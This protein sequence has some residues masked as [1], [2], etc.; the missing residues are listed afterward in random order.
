MTE[1]IDN[2]KLLPRPPIVVV[3]G[4][5][6]H[7]KTTLLDTIR[8]TNV[9]AKE[10]GGI[11]QSVGAYEITHPQ[12]NADKK[13]AQISADKNPRESAASEGSPSTSSGRPSETSGRKITFI[14]TPGHEAFSKMRSRGA[15][16]ADLAVL[17][18]AAD[19]GVKP[20]TKES[21]EVLQRTETPFIVAITKIDKSGADVEK[22]KNDLTSAG[23]LLEGYG[24]EVSYEPVSAK[25][26]EHIP[27]LLD[28]ILLAADV[29]HLIY[30]PAAT[31]EGFILEARVDRQRG[32]EA[33]VIVKNGT[34]RQGDQIATPTARGRIKI[35]EN[36]LGKPAKALEPSAPAL[37][38]GFEKLPQV[39][40][41]FRS[42]PTLDAN[43]F[44][45]PAAVPAK[46]AMAP[47]ATRDEEEKPKLNVILK[48]A[49]G[50]ALEALSGIVRNIA[51]EKPLKVA[52]ESVGDV[53]DNDVKL[54]ISTG[55][56][57][58]AFRSRTDK[59]SKSLAEANRITVIASDV[60]YDLVKAIEEFLIQF[61]KPPVTGELEVLAIFNQTKPEK[62]IVGGKVVSGVFKDKASVQIVRGDP[63]TPSTGS[64]QASSGQ[65]RVVGQGRVLNLQQQKKDT[66]QV[67]AGNEA[68]VLVSSPML[69]QTGDKLVI[70]Q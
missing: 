52:G 28:L 40:E 64:G 56:V 50:G 49:D 26:G 39:G 5:V 42:A 9:A 24:G 30:D 43:S 51:S 7:G 35:M 4:H 70:S 58:I 2:E 37:I 18:V 41:E 23:V 29:E 36:F 21:I 59:A 66:A 61:E 62:Q 60:I 68:G 34:L 22:T 10:A 53:N 47:L 48:A 44:A 3:M 69:I 12:I 17:V 54:A 20:Q 33:T 27:E 15:H 19:E 25:T 55:A 11:T 32:L 6:D 63:S 14:D 31:A 13:S 65:G 57:I 38:I 16:V 45:K 46:A 67:L 1:Q 8:K